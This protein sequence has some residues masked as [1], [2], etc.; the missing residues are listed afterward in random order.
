MAS[1]E[2]V[3]ERGRIA[4]GV[5][6][7]IRDPENSEVHFE[8]PRANESREIAV[9]PAAEFESMAVT[10]HRIETTGQKHVVLATR[11]D[12]MGRFIELLCNHDVVSTDTV[13]DLPGRV[14]VREWFE[15]YGDDTTEQVF[16]SNGSEFAM[17][18]N[19]LGSATL[20]QA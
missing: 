3:T 4:L 11:F 17:E 7:Y 6:S 13:T 14:T 15:K 18:I 16:T 12:G 1:K 19:R 20:I 10:L 8:G 9:V 2:T 5:S